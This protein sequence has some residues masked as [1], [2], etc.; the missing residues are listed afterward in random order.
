[1][2]A[3]GVFQ[4]MRAALAAAGLGEELNDVRVAVQGVG[5]VGYHLCSYLSAAGARLIVIPIVIFVSDVDAK[6]LS[7]LSGKIKGAAIVDVVSIGPNRRCAI[8]QTRFL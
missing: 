1:M 2:T 7:E 5:N 4:G 8:G 3:F 6:L